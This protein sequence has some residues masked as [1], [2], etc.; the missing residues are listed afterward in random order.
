MPFKEPGE[1]FPTT[2]KKLTRKTVKEGVQAVLMDKGGRIL[3]DCNWRICGISKKKHTHT[4]SKVRQ[5]LNT[6]MYNIIA[7]TRLDRSA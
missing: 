4:F 3:D 2:T 1:L 5:P 6:S 7:Q